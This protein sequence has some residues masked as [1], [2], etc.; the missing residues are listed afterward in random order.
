MAL[1]KREKPD[2]SALDSMKLG[3][4]YTKDG[5]ITYRPWVDGADIYAR[6]VGKGQIVLYARVFPF[7]TH[8]APMTEE[9]LNRIKAFVR[10]H[11]G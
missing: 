10:R 1:M 6:D 11:L 8:A 4:L 7:W 3:D 2:L 9:G 5:G